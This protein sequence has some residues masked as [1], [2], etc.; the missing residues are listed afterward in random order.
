MTENEIFCTCYFLYI[1]F[2]VKRLRWTGNIIWG[3]RTPVFRI[4]DWREDSYCSTD[5]RMFSRWKLQTPR[6]FFI[7]QSVPFSI[8]FKSENNLDNFSKFFEIQIF[9]NSPEKDFSSWD[10]LW[11]HWIESI[12]T[13][14]NRIIF[15]LFSQFSRL[16]FFTW[17]FVSSI[18]SCAT[19]AKP[20]LAAIFIT[21]IHDKSS[22]SFEECES[23]T[24]E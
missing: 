1:S 7:S 17:S 11:S 24:F 18:I 6:L 3:D 10:P 19:V 22:I 9:D 4:W 2:R 20:A 14:P 12:N 15:W 21:R 13:V 5:S 23:I 16:W 8:S